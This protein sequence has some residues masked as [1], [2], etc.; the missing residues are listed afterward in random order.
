M[1]RFSRTDLVLVTGRHWNDRASIPI[2]AEEEGL[3]R[4]G[5]TRVLMIL[6]VWE[7]EDDHGHRQ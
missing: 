5:V 7:R 1:P 6:R 2:Y 3:P 4:V